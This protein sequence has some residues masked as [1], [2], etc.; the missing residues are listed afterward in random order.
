VVLQTVAIG[1]LEAWHTALQSL[2]D[3]QTLELGGGDFD[4]ASVALD[5]M[6]ITIRGIGS[7]T[8]ILATA[9][10]AVS[11]SNN[12]KLVLENVQLVSIPGANAFDGVR[13]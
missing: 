2:A 11:I 13:D 5:S 4:V 3:L 1:N 7:T 8:R 6:T 10:A 12:A 9:A